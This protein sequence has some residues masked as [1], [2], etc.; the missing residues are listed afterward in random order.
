LQPFN[1]NDAVEPHM[2]FRSSCMF[3]DCGG[4]WHKRWYLWD[5]FRARSLISLVLSDSMEVYERND[6]KRNSVIEFASLGVA[7]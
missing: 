2:M 5:I 4:I 3:L 1:E 7:V 6:K